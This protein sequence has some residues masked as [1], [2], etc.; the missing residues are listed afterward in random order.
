MIDGKDMTQDDDAQDD[1]LFAND[2]PHQLWARLEGLYLSCELKTLTQR[3]ARDPQRTEKMSL[4]QGPLYLDYSKHHLD[5]AILNAL[6]QLAHNQGFEQKRQALFSGEAIN[7]SENRAALHMALRNPGLETLKGQ[8][9]TDAIRETRQRIDRFATQFCRGEIKGFTGKPLHQVIHIGIGGSYLGPKMLHEALAAVHERKASCHY[10][11]NIDGNQLNQVLA[12][13]NPETCLVI[14]ASKSF[15]TLETHINARA[16]RDH[17]LTV[18]SEA[19]LKH[20]FVGVT[21]NTAQAL[22]FGISEERL[23]PLWDQIGGRYSVWSA[24][25]LPLCLTYGPE[26]FAALLAGASDMDEHFRTAPA[27]N[28]MPLIMALLTVWYGHFFNA[29]S[30]AIVPYDHSLRLFPAHL[31]QLVMESNG[32]SVK[33]DGTPVSYSTSPV[34]WGA[35]GTNGQHA[36][37]QLLHQGTQFIPVDFI[38][39]MNTGHQRQSHQDNM[40]AN[41]LAQSLALMTGRQQADIRSELQAQG[42]DNETAE[43][44]ASHRA[45]PGNRPSTTLILDDLSAGT[46]GAM[47]ALYEHRVFCE[48][49]LWQI[50]P[51]DQWG[52]ELGKTLS[53]SIHQQIINAPEAKGVD[54]DQDQD[55]STRQLLALYREARDNKAKAEKENTKATP[56]QSK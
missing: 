38:L 32:K 1:S 28:N 26:V 22:A 8:P 50:N 23:F 48:A 34:V 25:G 41:C 45:C 47:L 56:T 13:V 53:Q 43:L 36:F 5:Q 54:T 20:H 42:I 37:H 29:H 39:P 10:I 11:A 19:Q 30:Q 49:I 18:M 15:S 3:F 35:E 40:V 33:Q 17:F 51:F 7:Q 46:L 24:V 2:N 55:A 9:L 52:V 31:Q 16:V 14:V 21:A 44:M 12:A 27:Q 6:R 4:R